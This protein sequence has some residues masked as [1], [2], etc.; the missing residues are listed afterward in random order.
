MTAS[1]QSAS[2]TRRSHTLGGCNTCRRRHVK[3]DQKRPSCQMCKVMGMVCEGF[4]DEIRWMPSRKH[5]QSHR[6]PKPRGLNSTKHGAR[7]HLYTEQSRLSMSDALG[8]ELV[9]GSIDASLA[10]ID[11]K[12][13]DP[14]RPMNEDIVIGPFAVLDFPPAPEER[15]QSPQDP[16]TE[17]NHD[18]PVEDL[19][20]DD[21]YTSSLTRMDA[22]P[23]LNDFLQWS[24]IF[25]LGSEL[26][27]SFFQDHFKSQTYQTFPH[28]DED[29]TSTAHETA[30]A[31]SRNEIWSTV[32]SQT[33][34]DLNGL[35]V[36]V[37]SDAPFL[38]R[39]F[40]DQVI[41]RIMAVPL[42]E[43]TPWKLLNVPSALV[44]YT[45][46][47]F[48]GSQSISHARQANLYCLLACSAMHLSLNPSF[49]IVGSA[50][51]WKQL[52]DRTYNLAKD[53]M[54]RSLKDETY[55]PKKAKYKDQL[56]AICALTEFAVLSGQQQDA[57][58]YMVDAERLLRLRG[59][60]KRNISQ[61]AR[62]LHH[63][64]TWLRI[65][66][67]STYALHDYTPHESF[68]KNIN[69]H[70]RCERLAANGHTDMGGESDLRLDDFLRIQPRPSDS[71]L[72]IDEP[73]DDEIG[74]HDIHLLDSRQFSGTLYRQIYGIPETW[75]SLVSQTT[76][77][78]NVM[79][80]L[81]VLRSTSKSREG[82]LEALD[83]LQRRSARL[84]NM[85]C[86]FKHSKAS[87]PAPD[88]ADISV[89]P[90]HH[91]IRALDS[92]LVIFFY[93]RIRQVHP[94]ILEGHIDDVISALQDFNAS[95]TE[96]S[97]TGPGTVWP[98]FIAGCEAMTSVRRESILSLLEAGEAKCQFAPF[99]TARN[100]MMEVWN[101]QDDNSAS[102]QR[103]S[104]P[105]WL[106]VVQ[107]RRIWPM[108]C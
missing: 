62:L 11:V 73:K 83:V 19:P 65:V 87:N 25:M 9:S 100:V 5:Q 18:L 29:Q 93:R 77:L 55:E 96:G 105:S 48:M 50:E 66:G 42:I 106:D 85:I 46:L 6:N 90:H 7:R 8:A 13:R 28:R 12:S 98:L 54:Q 39:H 34:V 68:V 10:E 75:L 74:L 99:R 43:K 71:D 76:R 89:A 97:Q 3:C 26:P 17:M 81:K 14:E 63:V 44:T 91:F 51:H 30:L 31:S 27:G 24:D 107:R 88:Q 108:L 22:L 37:P 41:P 61:K 72:N 16:A 36:G 59:L 45:D 103:D 67:E 2:R 69:R 1:R 33:P 15:S 84:E 70:S 95:L 57:R 102:S 21:L 82:V 20:P 86:S 40:Q 23:D 80:T 4:S 78:A 32:P 64:Y 79:E 58:C 47:T 49:G 53:H 35:S 38:L 60:P 92:A 104:I 52:T 94:S 101:C 56:M